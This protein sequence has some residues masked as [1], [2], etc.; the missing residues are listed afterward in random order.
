MDFET[1][2]VTLAPSFLYY[3]S[4]DNDT[5]KTRPPFLVENRDV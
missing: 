3:L 1:S 5:D 4:G 2:C